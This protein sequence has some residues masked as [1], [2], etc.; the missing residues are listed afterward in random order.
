MNNGQEI[1]LI[2]TDNTLLTNNNTGNQTLGYLVNVN[3]GCLSVGANNYDIYK[4]DDKN[5]N[6]I[7]KMDHILN[8]SAYQNIIDSS[9]PVENTNFSKIN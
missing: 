5:M 7:F 3:N 2:S 4:C 8:E 6:Q 9:L 1:N